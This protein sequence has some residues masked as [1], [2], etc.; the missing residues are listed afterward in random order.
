MMAMAET[1]VSDVDGNG[2]MDNNDRFGVLS[3]AGEAIRIMAFGMGYQI[4]STDEDG[5]PIS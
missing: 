5:F 3:T 2:V 4:C 1:A